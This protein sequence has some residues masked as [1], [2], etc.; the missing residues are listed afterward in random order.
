MTRSIFFK[1]LLISLLVLSLEI[2]H[3]FAEISA[4]QLPTG[5]KIVSG[6]ITIKQ[7]RWKINNQSSEQ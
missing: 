2:S 5:A 3:S 6:D 1:S 7:A 4:N